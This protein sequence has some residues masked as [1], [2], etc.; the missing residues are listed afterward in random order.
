M[1]SE[2]MQALA[3][4]PDGIYVDLTYGGGG[5]SR[6]I[7]KA[8]GNGKL[9]AFDQ[10][11]DVRPDI[12]DKERFFFFRANYRFLSH[13]LSYL[14]IESV[15]GIFADLGVSW[16]Q[17]DEPGR[18]FTFRSDGPLDMRMS[19]QGERTAAALLNT[20]PEDKLRSVFREYGELREA[21][22]IA[23]AIVKERSI[24]PIQTS[25]QLNECLRSL[26]P[27]HFPNRFLARVYQAIRIEVNQEQK[28]LGEMLEQ[29]PRWIKPGG[30]LVI[31]AYHSLE[32]RMVKHF[33]K[34]GNVR[35]EVIRDLYGN[36]KA[37][38]VPVGSHAVK[39][40]GEE[41]Q[42]NPRARSARLRVGERLKP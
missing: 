32:D 29:T 40:S 42:A 17:F 18:G 8:L 35:G 12:S 16:H 2:S 19:K 31:I 10:D 30:R 6:E 4:K 20:L 39:P 34:T 33:L 3:I 11:P 26:I 14:G 28:C 1:L 24:R 27:A 25:A 7:M 37:P 15:D 21:G 13:F 23:R 9:I 22:A 41:I 5:H 38:F 36:M